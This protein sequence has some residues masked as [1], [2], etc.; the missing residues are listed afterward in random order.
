M[1][2]IVLTCP[3]TG[4]DFSTG[5]DIDRLSFEAIPDA[6][7]RVLPA[8]RANSSVAKPPVKMG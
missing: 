7:M 5:I 3:V 6:I 2:V 8:L 4:D 1:G